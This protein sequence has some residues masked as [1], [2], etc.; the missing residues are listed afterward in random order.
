MNALIEEA[1]IEV[2]LIIRAQAPL[3]IINIRIQIG[4]GV[5]QLVE[6]LIILVA[7]D[8]GGRQLTCGD[9]GIHFVANVIVAT[10]ILLFHGDAARVALVE[11]FNQCFQFFFPRT[12]VIG[13]P[14]N[15]L[16][17]RIDAG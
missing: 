7:H 11:F 13:P 14:D 5:I 16:A 17:F 6:G 2:L 9:T 1:R 15:L 10:L 8:Q 4:Q 12:A 3:G